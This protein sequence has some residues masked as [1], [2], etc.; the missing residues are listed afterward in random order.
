MLSNPAEIYGILNLETCRDPGQHFRF[1]IELKISTV[2]IRAKNLPPLEVRQLVDHLLSLRNATGA[3]T[4]K[5]V[6]NDYT[7]I[8]LEGRVDGVHLGQEDLIGVNLEQLRLKLGRNAIIGIS[9]HNL[10]QAELADQL[11]VSY[12]AVGP[13]FPSP[14]KSGH[15]AVIGL[16]GLKEIATAVTKPIVAIGGISLEN[17]RSVIDAGASQVALISALEDLNKRSQIK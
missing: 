3:A 9:T 4:P 8:A 5:V 11:P 7:D 13:I 17:L 2:Q 1:L 15:A 12:I 6:I 10:K 14:T 16:E